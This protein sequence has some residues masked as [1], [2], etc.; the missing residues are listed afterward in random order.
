MEKGKACKSKHF[1]PLL[2][3]PLL[4]L[5]DDDDDLELNGLPKETNGIGVLEK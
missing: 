4:L 3:V 2:P 5:L 1:L